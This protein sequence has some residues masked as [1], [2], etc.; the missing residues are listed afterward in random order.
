MTNQPTNFFAVGCACLGAVGGIMFSIG[1][2]VAGTASIDPTWIH[3]LGLSAFTIQ[4]VAAIVFGTSAILAFSEDE[5]AR[6]E[7]DTPREVRP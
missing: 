2:T 1:V 4:L 5:L 6:Y 3:A 7:Q